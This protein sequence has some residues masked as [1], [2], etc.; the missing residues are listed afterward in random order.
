[1]I[2]FFHQILNN[3]MEKIK[4]HLNRISNLLIYNFTLSFEDIWRVNK[5]SWSSSPFPNSCLVLVM[6]SSNQILG[7]FFDTQTRPESEKWY[8][9]LT[10]S[11]L[12]EYQNPMPKPI[13][14]DL[15]RFAKNPKTWGKSRYF[16]P[17]SNRNPSFVARTHH[18]L[19][20]T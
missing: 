7:N 2:I 11:W 10:P 9:N 17:D 14:R 3:F 20:S 12:L 6:G 15:F 1:M 16:W 5:S 13:N 4:N 18:Y 19:V 8:L